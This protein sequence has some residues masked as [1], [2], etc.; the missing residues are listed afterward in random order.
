MN[1]IARAVDD[2]LKTEF[3]IAG[4][5]ADTGKIKIQGQELH[6]VQ[7]LDPAACTGTFL[8]AVIRHIHQQ[9]A[10][11]SG[12]WNAY[13]DEHLIP[14]LHGFELLMAAYTICHTKLELLLN[15]T[16]YKSRSGQRL[17]VYLTNTLE[18]ATLSTET[19]FAKWLSDEASAANEV[20]RDCPVMVV[21][22]NPPYSGESENKGSWITAQ[23]SDYKFEP[24]SQQKLNEGISKWLS[25]DYVKF[26]RYGE[27]LIEKK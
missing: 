16:G 10:G 4:G 18:E 2:I 13:V 1:F 8:S 14:R 3:A 24:D 25:D 20:K 17:K 21:L 27:Q 22:G 6:R 9:Y 26:I 11:Q 15:E 7:I 12:V 5:L 23:I 19:L